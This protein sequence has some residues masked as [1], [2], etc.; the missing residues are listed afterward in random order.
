MSVD[1]IVFEDRV[2]LPVFQLGT[3]VD[4]TW[5]ITVFPREIGRLILQMLVETD[6][7]SFFELP[8]L[9]ARSVCSTWRQL[10]PVNLVCRTRNLRKTSEIF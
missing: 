9:M 4:E 2:T 8:Y 6:E 7:G 1:E 10:M 5:I 3:L